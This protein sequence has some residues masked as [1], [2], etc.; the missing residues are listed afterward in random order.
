MAEG[1][2]DAPLDTDA[3][4]YAFRRNVV[5]AASA[6]TGK[7]YR[8]T[9]LYVLL[10]L[11]LTSMGERDDR[12]AA[13]AVSPER[14]VA[15]TFSRAAA[16][17]IAARVERALR[18]IAGWDGE[19]P[20][21]QVT[22]GAVIAARAEILGQRLDR[23]ELQKRAGEALGRWPSARIDT[24]HGVARR[25][26]QRHA[27]AIGLA[28]G[29][30][31]LDEEEA[32]ALADLAVDEALGAA[33]TAGGERAEAARGLIVS[34]GSVW[35]TR[36]KV[37]RLLDRLDEEGLTPAELTLADHLGE[38]RAAAAALLALARR[39][40]ALGSSTFREPAAALAA[41]LARAPRDDL[42]PE[43]AEASLME[44]F[45]R[46][47][48]ARGKRLPPDDELDDFIGEL[49]G[50]TKAD[51]AA[52][53][54][55][56]LRHAPG[57]AAREAGL[58]A[59]LEDAR[60]RLAAGK[61]RAGALGFGDLLRTARDTLRD[62]PEIARAAREEIDALLVDEF[63]DQSRVQ[64]DLVYLLRERD[65]A[66]E[67]RA[68][69]AAPE[70]AGL[71]PHGLFLVGDRKQSIYGFRGADVA[72]S[73]RIAAELAGRAAGIA[74]ALPEAAW[75]STTPVADFAA[76]RE[77][78]RSGAAIL[79]FVN[80]FAAR[81]FAGERPT[82]TPPRAFEI[83]YGPAEHLEP[84]A[85]AAVGPG[86]VVFIPDDGSSPE[87]ADPIVRESSG[88]AREAHVAAAY[89]AGVTHG[90]S[91]REDV[92]RYQDVAILARRRSTIPLVEL[93]LARLDIP[94]V[95]AG[96]ALYDAPEVRDVA[97]ILRLLL[98]PRDRLAM[99]A[100][101]RGPVVALSDTALA[102]LSI[103]GRGLAVPVLGRWPVARAPVD[104]PAPPPDLVDPSRLAPDERARL[105]AFRARFAE[106]RGAALRLPP[107]EAI[108]AATAV[109]DLDRVLAA[110]PRAEARLGNLDRLVTIARRRGGTLAAFVRWLERRMRD[111][112]DE[113]E[114]A[115]FSPE[116][117]AVRL[118][119]IHAS[120]GLD[121][122]VVVLVDLNAEP[123]G[124][125]AGLGF[126]ADG[127][128]ARLVVRHYAPRGSSRA[129]A[130]LLTATLRAAQSEARAREQ[131]E[132]RR[133]TYVA[134]TRARHTLALVASA[135]PPRPGSALRSLVAGLAAGDVA[136]TA[137]TPATALLA[138]ARPAPPRPPAPVPA[139]AALPP[140]PRSSPAREIAIDAAGLALFRECPRRFRL[141][142]LL[143]IEEP[144]GSSQLDLFAAADAPEPIADLPP[145]VADDPALDPSPRSRA[146][147]VV[148]ARWPRRAF[149]RPTDGLA[150][151]ARLVAA[152]LPPGDAET[153]RLARAL[154]SFLA[155]PYARAV[156][157]EASAPIGDEA[158]VIGIDAAGREPRRLLLRGTID[159]R[160]DR[161][162]DRVDVLAVS[163]A[164][165]RAVAGAPEAALRAAALAVAR[166]RPAAAVRAGVLFLGGGAEIVWLPGGGPEGTLTAADHARFADEAGALA[167]RL[168]EATHDE[169]F[170]GI[171]RARCQKLGCGFLAACHGTQAV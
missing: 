21:E 80:A 19:G 115:V 138:E 130:P 65:D 142:R 109:F 169:S 30:R 117:D 22:F 97:A 37:L 158:F 161:A 164:R 42:L 1:L 74:L 10:A 113:A 150:V 153:E 27:L 71:R 129:L 162:G 15:T 5:V 13:K 166:S 146:P 99:A 82:G 134:V 35:A 17:E 144:A 148:L 28:P 67:Q 2:A 43:A 66:A 25:V 83:A 152:G 77:S 47:L 23:G 156:R 39:L 108:R 4:I 119:T 171:P 26:V 149:G 124:D 96:R 111:D 58:L 107:G 18:E 40:A 6:G 131:A 86:R 16:A 45:T 94:Y 104:P 7:T 72:V 139:E 59:L 52:G 101:L 145:P 32:Q 93:A 46:R 48:P 76:L 121:F 98:D 68:P 9:A 133:L 49:H 55:A 165:A 95:V 157:A 24:L 140:R 44:L 155:G 100:V 61:R 54:A 14:I 114:A 132:R 84:A 170:E 34:A 60:A 87:G 3:T 127:A 51:R 75:A 112:A 163:E 125:H 143:G 159:L 147:H 57:L 53:L 90:A 141:R 110:L 11:G 62:R 29:T 38:G 79:A 89:V 123:R 64:R 73:S 106:I 105:E 63:Q 31:V 20:L 136:V 81:D 135:S 168:A 8:L 36:Q 137:T 92:V 154:A 50:K 167:Q 126:V 70:A 120:K 160:V 12:T 102:L 85:G 78:R 151:E 103:P 118:T 91:D 88:A 122:P 33:L 56:L 41:A 116:D 69:G 128:G